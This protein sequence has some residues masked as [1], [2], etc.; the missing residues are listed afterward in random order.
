MRA[1]AADLD[2]AARVVGGN[3]RIASTLAAALGDRVRLTTPVTGIAVDDGHAIL[4]TE[5]ESL[6][7]DRAVIAVPLS[8]LD[9]LAWE[10]G[11]PE[12]WQDGCSR[13]RD[14]HRG[15]AV[16]PDDQPARDPTGCSTRR[17]HG[18]RGTRSTRPATLGSGRCP[19]S[20]EAR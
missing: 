11:F 17:T 7:V 1:A 8:L 14:R 12:T 5:R 18:G 20:Q 2:A 9:E 4:S 3:Q 16:G 13:P 19:A 6:L 15:Q 10:P